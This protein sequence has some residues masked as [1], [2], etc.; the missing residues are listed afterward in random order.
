MNQPRVGL[1]GVTCKYESGGQR[2]E[3][4]LSGI[5]DALKKKNLDVVCAEK[6][7]WDSADAID[8]CKQFKKENLDA[9]VIVEVTWT[10]DSMQYLF[11]NELNL[12]TVFW[13]VPYTETFS[14]GFVQHFGSILKAQ[15]YE[16]DYV[17]GLPEDESLSEKVKTVAEAGQIIKAVKGMR[18]ALVGPR[19]TWRVAGSQDMS[20]EEWEFSRKFGVTLVHVEMSEITDIS[21]TISDE[22]AE[23][24]LSCL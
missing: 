2:A 21:D 5:K 14:I 23:K 16:Y 11:I 22:E 4:L 12:P 3:E 9:L 13:A 17:Y 19:Q 18:L 10:L 8:V 1:V 24:K 20:S 7:A 6:V 15:G